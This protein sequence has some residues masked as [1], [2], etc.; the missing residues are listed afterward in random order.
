MG[1]KGAAKRIARQLR[2]GIEADNAIFTKEDLVGNEPLKCD[3][4]QALAE[5]EDMVGL[6]HIKKSVGSLADQVNRNFHLELQGKDPVKVNFNRVFL[7]ELGTGKRSVAVLYGR[8]LA[9]LGLISSTTIAITTPPELVP[10]L[11]QRQNAQ[12]GRLTQKEMLI[13]N[14]AHLLN[15]YKHSSLCSFIGGKSVMEVLLMEAEKASM[16]NRCIILPG[17]GEGT[18]E[19]FKEHDLGFAYAFSFDEALCFSSFG[20]SE[21]EQILDIKLRKRQL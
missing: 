14:D 13:I 3:Q 4:M 12:T 10:E 11:E 20:N 1:A 2:D 17:Q 5:L 7:G 16:K 8:I 21:L 18:K 9:E 6:E 15:Q 19:R